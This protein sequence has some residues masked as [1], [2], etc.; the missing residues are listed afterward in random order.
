MEKI[1]NKYIFAA[2]AAFTVLA[3]PGVAGAQTF[4]PNLDTVAD[5]FVV[6]QGELISFVITRAVPLVLAGIA[7]I[8]GL[9]IAFRSG[10]SGLRWIGKRFG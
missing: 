10:I 5:F 9:M 8:Y 3:V 6:T 1:K 7:F 2:V 4:D